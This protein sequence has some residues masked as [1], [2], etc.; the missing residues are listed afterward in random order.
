[1][2]GE[3]A[4][5]FDGDAFT[6]FLNGRFASWLSQPLAYRP[7]AYPP[8]FLLLL[9]FA[10]LGFLGSYLTFQAATAG[11]MAIALRSCVANLMSSRRL[12]AVALLCP[13]SAI[14]VIDGQT[15]FLVT[16]LIVGG[17]GLMASRPVLAGLVL[18]LLTFKP[19]F[20]ILVP[21]ANPSPDR[22]RAMA[23]FFRGR[24]INAGNSGGRQLDLR[25]GSLAPLVSAHH[26]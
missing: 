3:V 20:C 9:P 17:I 14:N 21:L 16:A 26:R 8:S 12:I 18:G 7:S 5:I 25:M 1:L 23:R 11:L 13:A 24:R 22:G 19:Q 15:V 2:D 4:Q 6:E 10:P